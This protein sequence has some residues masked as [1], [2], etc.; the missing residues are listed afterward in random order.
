MV[1]NGGSHGGAASAGAELA[2]EARWEKALVPPEGGAAT[3]LIRIVPPV[4]PPVGGRRAPLDVAFALDR[5]GSMSGEKLTLVKEAVDVAVRLLREEDRVALVTYD[6]RVG[7]VQPLAAATTRT[8]TALRLAL[9]GLDAGGSTALADGWLTAC[10]ELAEAPSLADGGNGAGVR[11]RRALLLTDGLANV[12]ETDPAVLAEHAHELRRRGVGTTTLG[13]GVDFDE[14]LLAGLAEAGGGNFQ[15]IGKAA[16]LRAFFEREIGE[17]LSV[18]ASDLA[19][20]LT[21]PPGVRGTVVSAYPNQR[22]DQRIA[23]ALGDLPAGEE[24]P[25]LLSIQVPPGVLGAAQRIELEATWADPAADSRRRAAVEVA[26]LRYADAATVGATAPDPLVQE[27]AALQNAAA[28]QREAVRLDRAGRYAE[29]RRVLRESTALLSAAP[30]TARVTAYA[31]LHAQ[32]ADADEAA[33]LSEEARKQAT[34]TAHRTA[35][36]RRQEP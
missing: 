28:A 2:I 17:L 15:W 31:R 25:L 27:Q 5:S 33:P 35:R 9:H 8:K 32:F 36:G 20:T 12:G 24:I 34:W 14:A 7:V 10:R 6:N 11:I 21:L 16:E 1:E 22:T 18:A 29:S 13:V 30:A 23:V 4:Q 3:L 26:P 19:V